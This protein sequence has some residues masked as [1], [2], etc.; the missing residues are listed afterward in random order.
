MGGTFAVDLLGEGETGDTGGSSAN[1]SI[2]GKVLV[3]VD[4]SGTLS[5]FGAESGLWAR[6]GA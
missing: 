6:G 5:K 3:V 4:G 1:D 2:P